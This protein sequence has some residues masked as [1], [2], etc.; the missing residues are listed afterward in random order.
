MYLD[1]LIDVNEEFA[2][3]VKNGA[4]LRECENN[5]FTGMTAAEVTQM[6]NEWISSKETDYI[7]DCFMQFTRE[8][9]YGD[10]YRKAYGD[11]ISDWETVLYENYFYL[12]EDA[13][14]FRDPRSLAGVW[15]GSGYFQDNDKRHRDV[16]ESTELDSGRVCAVS[17]MGKRYGG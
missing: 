7:L 5:D 15:Q 16:S 10:F 1:D 13:L 6:T 11:R 14:C 4:V 9:L 3:L 2:M 17:D 12:E 8:Y